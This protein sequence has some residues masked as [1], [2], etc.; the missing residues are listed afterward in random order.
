MGRVDG[1]GPDAVGNR[2]QAGARGVPYGVPGIV[3]G[4]AY[5]VPGIWCPRNLSVEEHL[6]TGSRNSEQLRA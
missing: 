6:D 3:P 2:K 5:G 1:S 4:I